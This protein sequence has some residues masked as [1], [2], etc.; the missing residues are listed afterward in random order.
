MQDACNDCI[1]SSFTCVDKNVSDC[2]LIV[3]HTFNL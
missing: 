3:V 1:F 2:I